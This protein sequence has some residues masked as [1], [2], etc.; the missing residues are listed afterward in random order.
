MIDR[1]KVIAE[2]MMLADRENDDT[3]E[4]LKCCKI[5]ED[6]LTLLKEQEPYKSEE[7]HLNRDEY[8]RVGDV[9]DC[10]DGMDMKADEVFHAVCLI[11][12][13]MGKRSVP[14]SQLLK[15][16]EKKIYKEKDKGAIIPRG[17]GKSTTEYFISLEKMRLAG[18]I[19]HHDYAFMKAAALNTLCGVSEKGVIAWLEKE[20]KNEEGESE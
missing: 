8:C 7:T 19:S 14:L 9:L 11:E 20:L 13:A 10:F 12:W 16:Q 6:A 5:A 2:L 3:C 15:E 4:G 18:V 1:E 17:S